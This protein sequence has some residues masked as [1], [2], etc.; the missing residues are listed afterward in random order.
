MAGVTFGQALANSFEDALFR[1]LVDAIRDY[2]ILLLSP[3][4]KVLTW[5]L[6]AEV[7]M[8]YSR[9]EILGI[10]FSKFYLPEAIES[11]LPAQEL[12][13][14]ESAERFAGESW[15]IR[16][17]GSTFWASVIITPLRDSAG[18]LRGFAKITQDLTERRE[19]EARINNL[20]LQLHQISARILHVQDEERRRIARELHDDLG[21]QIAALKMFVDHSGDRELSEIAD[22]ALAYVRGLS[23]LLHPPLLDESGL[24]IAIKW[25]VEGFAKRSGIR[26]ELEIRPDEFPRIGRDKETAI[27]RV[28]QESLT[29]IF[30]HAK[31]DRASVELE[32]QNDRAVVRIRDYGKGLQPDIIAPAESKIIGVGIA[33][34]RERIRQFR[35]SLSISW[36]EPGT[37]VEATIPIDALDLAS[38]DAP[39]G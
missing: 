23:Y 10:H 34:M 12:A 1:Q 8:G 5:N 16:K 20:N 24:S 14:A 13:M 30:R 2:A 18:K 27:F 22:S 9:Q 32:M 21:N 19:A 28:I 38:V 36:C 11:G 6:G 4:G 7:L 3:D 37:L 31:T 33:G 26:I 39:P 15:H 29:N 17:D 25:F 35:G